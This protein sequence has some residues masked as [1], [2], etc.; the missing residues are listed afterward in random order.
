EADRMGIYGIIDMMEVVDPIAKLKSL[1]QVPRVVIL[2]RGIDT[3]GSGKKS[4][5]DLIKEIKAMY[6]DIRPPVLCA[7]AGGIDADTAPDA[8]KNGADILII[9]R[10]ITQSQDVERSIRN[11]INIMPGTSD[12]DLK[13]VHIDDD[14]KSEGIS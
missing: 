14:D 6:K 7:V 2:H 11:L 9:G 8:V 5:W 13:R 1:K 4:R 10:Y 3:E 12:V